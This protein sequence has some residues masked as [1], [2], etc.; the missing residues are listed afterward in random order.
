MAMNRA[1]VDI[2]HEPKKVPV[3]DW[4]IATVASFMG[5]IK[6]VN[7]STMYYRQHS[8]DSVGAKIM[9]I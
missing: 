7:K 1:L 2:L 6:F 3:H 9:S 8:E 5:K 4:W